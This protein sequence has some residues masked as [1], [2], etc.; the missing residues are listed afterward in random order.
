MVSVL[1]DGRM[2]PRQVQG[3]YEDGVRWGIHPPNP[4]NRG[5]LLGEEDENEKA[6]DSALNKGQGGVCIS[7]GRVRC[8]VHRHLAEG[9]VSEAAFAFTGSDRPSVQEGTLTILPCL[10]LSLYPI[11]NAGYL[12]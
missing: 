3:E 6:L 12:R 5:G 4:R 2:D 10:G 8:G 9:T 7:G 11:R 1:N